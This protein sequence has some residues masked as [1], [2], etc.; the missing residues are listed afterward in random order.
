MTDLDPADAAALDIARALAAAGI[1]VFYAY[2]DPASSTGYKLPRDWQHTEPDPLIVGG[3]QPGMALAAVMGAGLDLIDVDPR[4]GGHVDALNGALPKIRGRAATPSGG[5]HLFVSPLG[6]GSRDG[7]LPGIDVKG[8]LPDGSSRGFA[9]IAPTIRVSKISGQPAGYRWVEPPD[10]SQLTPDGTGGELAG[11]VQ[12]LR[13]QS[14]AVR[15]GSA[16]QTEPAG[17]VEA[18]WADV[19][20]HSSVQADKAIAAKLAEVREQPAQTGIGFRTVL[21]RAAVTLGGYVGAGY[22]DLAVAQA[23]LE[24][25]VSAV[26][27]NPDADDLLWIN[28]GLGDGSRRPFRVFDAAAAPPAPPGPPADP[29]VLLPRSARELL[30]GAPYEVHG[31]NDQ[32]RAMEVLARTR[33]VL[34]FAAETNQWLQRADVVW[35]AHS[36]D[37]SGQAVSAV[38]TLMPIGDPD[39]PKSTADYTDAHWLAHWRGKFMS[40][41]GA[42]PIERKIRTVVGSDDSPARVSLALTDA[43]PTVLWAGGYP[44]DLTACAEQLTLAA[45]DPDTPHMRSAAVAPL[46]V[47]TPAWDAFTA[48]V[49]PDPELR[50]WALNVLSIAV[51]G[52]PDAAL[53]ILIGPTRRGKTQLVNLIMRVLGS[54][55]H[56]AD[57]RLLQSGEAHASIVYALKGRRLS[58]IDEGPRE[59][60]WAQERLKQ[61]TGGG[62]LTGNA[63]RADPVTFTPTHTLVLTTNDEPQLIDAAIRARARLIPCDGDAD[64]VRATRATLGH[65][66]GAVWRAEAP[67]IL[68]GLMHRSA[69]WLA[70]NAISATD[71]GP[72]H[73][74]TLADAVAAEQDPVRGWLNDA[75]V[76]DPIGA[77]SR[78]LYVNFV[79]W[80]KAGNMHGSRIPS[81]TAWG[82]QLTTYGY[83]WEHRRDGNYRPLRV[84]FG[85]GMWEVV[86]PTDDKQAA[87]E[88]ETGHTDPAWSAEQ[89]L[90]IVQGSVQRCAGSDEKPCTDDIRRSEP[91]NSTLVKGVKGLLPLPEATN[92]KDKVVTK[93]DTYIATATAEVAE[94]QTPHAETPLT[95]LGTP[96]DQPIVAREGLPVRGLGQDQHSHIVGTDKI[97]GRTDS[98]RKTTAPP[99][100]KAAAREAAR[101]AKIEAAQGDYVGL[102]AALAPDGSVMPVD[103]AL[104][105]VVLQAKLARIVVDVEHTGYPIGHPDHRLRTIQLGD[106]HGAIVLAADDPAQVEL[107]QD[108]LA[109]AGVLEAFSATADL[110]PLAHV[111]LIEHTDAWRRMHDVVI[112]AKLAAPHGFASDAA[113]GLKELSKRHLSDP[114]APEREAARD[115]LFRAG[116]WKG[117]KVDP[118]D[119]IGE[120]G[121]AQVSHQHA[122]MA[123]YDG[124]DV[125]DTARLARVLP[126]IPAPVLNRERIAQ[127]L[128]ARVS[129]EGLE[130]N[131]DRV[132]QLLAEHSAQEAHYGGII[133][134]AGVD[135][136]RGA[137]MAQR[138]TELGAR[139]PRTKPSATFPEGKPSVAA[140]VLASLADAPGQLGVVVT[141]LREHRKHAQRVSAF[142]AP[143]NLLVTAG[144]GKARPTVYTL[145]ADTGRMSCVRPN[146]QQVPRQGG[147]RSCI[148]AKDGH[149]LVAADFAN[150]ELR[151]AAALSQDTALIKLLNGGAD[152]HAMITAQVFGPAWTKEDRY[153]T[154]RVVFGWLYGQGVPGAAKTLGIRL[155]VAQSIADRLAE[156]S[157]RLVQWSKEFAQAVRGGMAQFPTHSGRI[158][159]LDTKLPHKAVNYA[160]Q[161]SAR[162][163]L[164]DT[165]VKLDTTWLTDMVLLPVHDELI[166]QVPDERA[167]EVAVLLHDLMETELH[168]VHIKSEAA[169]P[170]KEW[171]DAS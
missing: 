113:A 115:R 109:R 97:S 156:L 171:A 33:P 4:S 64:A 150:V 120:S 91:V 131:A 81:E 86:V 148:Q 8:G 162:E 11:M 27:G 88:L 160:V 9:F 84:N 144:D 60:R 145:Q 18:F 17:P 146:L 74:R 77:K 49:W 110:A 26:W 133:R 70:D 92:E 61:L 13:A 140:D 32:E 20:P 135:N 119:P 108:I 112:P 43:D 37:L 28:Q 166:V 53:P 155:D 19:P 96:A 65:L 106:E 50:E 71:A 29:G 31:R 7:V 83:P 30:G 45:V 105:R 47:P 52:Y 137:M 46:D 90:K 99:E 107:V 51:T 94:C 14:M 36:R 25:S 6:V 165:L 66:S 159:H 34:R 76:P 80:C 154:K 134:S 149:V 67:G 3:W 122:T 163:L 123:G 161:G 35:E 15:A 78:V 5:M 118:L 56:A 132:A 48:A 170:S 54:Y 100:A 114:L 73:V 79:E 101:R 116:R 104:A 141:A 72:L 21:M 117:P 12:A 87:Y 142:L 158:V 40:S 68:A 63:M 168:G 167:P 169:A 126:I 2:P 24:A 42:L 44:F 93:N 147:F 38:A 59:G 58:F 82:R 127:R 55:A 16:P 136:P 157:P 121:W 143:W 39:L 151:V 69:R 62:E 103:L 129:H 57:P 152:V 1:P 10:L 85:G 98:K 102:P 153:N 124:A 164:V 89:T 111:G 22:L 128:V 95:P 138:L 41:A 139:L 130:L 75:V 125:I 23:A